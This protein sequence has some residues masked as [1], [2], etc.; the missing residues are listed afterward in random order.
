M[1]FYHPPIFSWLKFSLC[2]ENWFNDVVVAS[3]LPAA[4]LGPPSSIEIMPENGGF[5]WEKSTIDGGL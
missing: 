3:F 1:L 4:A 2:T 5:S